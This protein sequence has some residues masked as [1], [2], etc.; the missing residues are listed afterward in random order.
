MQ[1][2]GV[3]TV[4]MMGVVMPEKGRYRDFVALLPWER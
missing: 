4:K 3:V 2:A 1:W